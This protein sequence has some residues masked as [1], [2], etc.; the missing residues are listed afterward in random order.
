MESFRG[1]FHK[2]YF[3]KNSILSFVGSIKLIDIYLQRDSEKE[4]VQVPNVGPW[5]KSSMVGHMYLDGPFKLR[6]RHRVICRYLDILVFP[7]K[8]SIFL[9]NLIHF[10]NLFTKN[11]LCHWNHFGVDLIISA[12][13]AVA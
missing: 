5:S 3:F 4:Y 13:K 10:F 1:N 2:K 11:L 12:F 9:L 8:A 7:S 6:C